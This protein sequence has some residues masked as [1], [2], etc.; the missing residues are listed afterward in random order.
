MGQMPNELELQ[1][2]FQDNQNLQSDKTML[3]EEIS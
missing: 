1:K 2:L 3:C